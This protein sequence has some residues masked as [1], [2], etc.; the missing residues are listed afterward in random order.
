MTAQVT[1]PH[2]TLDALAGETHSFPSSRPTLLCFVKE[3]CPT[4][5]LSMPLIEAA[6][7]A[8][9]DRI[10]VLAIGQDRPGNAALVERFKL[11]VPMLD[12][13]ALKISFKYDIETVPTIIL[14]DPNGSELRRFIG[15]GR[16]DWQ[17]LC[18]EMAKLAGKA[19]PTVDWA[20][21]PESRPGCGSKSVE[22]GVAERLQAEAE[23]SPIRARRIEIADQDDI[24]EFMFDQGLTDGLPVVPPT[25]ERVIRMLKGTR[26][27]AQE[28]LGTVAPSY[29][30]LTIEKVAINAVMAGC[31]PEYFPVVLAA[32]EII[33]DPD[34]CIHGISATTYGATPIIVVNGPIRHKIGMNMGINVLGQGNR[35]NATIGRA[36]KLIVRNVG[37]AKPGG[38]ERATFGS[39]SKYTCCFAEYEERSPWEPLHVERGFKKEASVVTMFGLESGPRQIADQTSR[40]ARALVG[41]I[42]LGAEASWHPKTHNFGDVLLVVSP[43]HADTIGHDKWSKEQVRQQ[44]QAVTS[45][46]L[47]ELLPTE[48]YGGLGAMPDQANLCARSEEELNKIIPKFQSTKNIHIVVAGGPAGKWTVMFGGWASGIYGSVPTSRK[49]EEVI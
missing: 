44:I 12:D 40:T 49:I 2:F 32:S 38:V 34:Y 21:Y 22:P 25:P 33:C 29:A 46:P 26:R 23:G 18:A 17:D 30:P 42:G 1:L 9:G 45:R 24:F 43:E 13:S 47:R 6:Y 3:D 48:D 31:K 5:V 35:P 37:G 41:S 28:I 16:Q 8:F 11:T 15:F 20:S 4:C 19:A 7:R 10:D 36:I 14:A 39:A 27:D